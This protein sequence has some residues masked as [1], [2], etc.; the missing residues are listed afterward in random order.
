MQGLLESDL[1]VYATTAANGRESSWGTY[2]PGMNPSPPPE[3]N[4]CLGDLYRCGGDNIS[5][6]AGWSGSLVMQRQGQD[7]SDPCCG[8]HSWLGGMGDALGGAYALEG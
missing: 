6:L 2:C 5:A 8:C 3:F 1:E 7:D 4:T